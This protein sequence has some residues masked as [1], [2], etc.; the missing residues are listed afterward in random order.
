MKHMKHEYK[1]KDAILRNHKESTLEKN[2]K[3]RNKRKEM[4]MK[5]MNKVVK[6]PF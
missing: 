2:E 4:L 5:E 1:Q 3:K 6:D